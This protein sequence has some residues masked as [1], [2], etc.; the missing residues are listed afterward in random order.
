[1]TAELVGIFE[2]LAVPAADQEWAALFAVRPVPGSHS[3][4]VGKDTAG[5]ACLLVST[6]DASGRAPPPIRLESLD[7]QFELG[8]RITDAGGHTTDGRFTVA[9]CRSG[10]RE[11]IRYFLSVCDIIMRHLGDSPSRSALASAVQ[12]LASIFQSIRIPP[13]RSLNGL[14]GELFLIARSRNPL[15]AVA[16]WRIDNG[17]RFDFSV[18]DIR[19]DVKTCTGRLRQHSFS[20]DQCNPP[21]GTQA[22]AASLMAER[23]P[24]GLALSDMIAGIEVRIA[25]DEDLVLKLHE[26]VA[27][28]LGTSLAES[29]AVTFDARLAESTMLFF[30]LRT[31]P[32][33]RDVLAPGVSDVRFSSNLSGQTPLG[34]ETLI[35]RDPLFW[36]LLPA[37]PEPGNG[38]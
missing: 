35:D 19:L 18:A 31:I 32:A 8:C 10:E 36:D 26:I 25:A 21:P 23:V 33:V 13:V 34:T 3:Y 14:F 11:T 4:F 5:K 27:A 38:P 28:T 6:S 37:E 9:R 17:A 12:R 1:M 30:D 20:Y 24:G 7:A 22:V 16:A 29:L 15:R 2:G